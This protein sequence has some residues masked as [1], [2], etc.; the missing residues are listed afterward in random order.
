MTW[1]YMQPVTIKFG[2][3]RIKEL[4]KE[5]KSLGGSRGILITS[6]S[7]KRRGLADS[8]IADSEGLIL[9][10]YTNVSPNPDIVEVEACISII[11]ANSCDFV[12]ALG[13]GSVLDCAKAAA[14][15]CTSDRP[16]SD[17]M[18]DAS[19]L[20]NTSIPMIAVPTTAGTGS[21]IT[22]V[23]VLSDHIIGVKKPLACNAFYPTLAIIDPELTYTVPRHITACTGMDVFCHALEAYWSKNHQPLCDALAIHALKLVFDHLRTACDE[24]DN[25]E[26]REKMAE[27]SVIAGLAFTLPKTNS[28]HACSYPLT[29]LLGIPHGEACAL[30]IDRFL[31]INIKEDDGRLMSLAK[32]LGFNCP[33]C[34][35]KA[36]RE[37]KEDI[38]IM[39]DLKS[40]NITDDQFDMLVEGSKFPTLLANPVEIT[41][42]ILRDMYQSMR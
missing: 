9:A 25:A 11:K 33:N 20:P 24:P 5:V 6:P 38:G 34:M 36:L 7:F 3:G 1:D 28:S 23:S 27:A 30:T 39:P 8:I 12:V 42:E 17:Y 22:S 29:N 10:A 2:N 32:S 31:A 18:E 21:E 35:L 15:M 19:L 4:S 14:V 40:L 16:V 37:L 41:D 13:G 26:A